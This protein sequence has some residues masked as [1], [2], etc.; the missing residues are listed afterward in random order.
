M[1]KLG[2]FF[3]GIGSP[4]LAFKKIG[5]DFELKF[6]SE[7]DPEDD[8][9]YA[10]KSYSIIHD[11]S[12]DMNLGDI[13]TI[14]ETKLPYCDIYTYGFPCQSFSMQGK[15]LGF[16]DPVKGNLFFETMRIANKNK[17]KILIAENVKGLIS[18]D[19][20]N[21]FK[22]ILETLDYIGYN[23]YYSIL[24]SC[25][26]NLPHNRERIF[27]VSIRKDVDNNLFKMPIGKLT[28]LT[29]NDILDTTENRKGVKESLLNYFNNKYFKINYESPVGIKKL[30]DGVAEGY[31]TSSFTSNR[32]FST[33]G[34]SPT[35][36]TKNDAVYYEINGH[37]TQK[38]RFRLQGIPDEY[39]YRL[40]D[41]G[42]PNGALDKISGNTLSVNVFVAIIQELKNA[43]LFENYNEINISC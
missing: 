33:N 8:K 13:N 28:K 42:I 19:N 27:I 6:Y 38:E 24:N 35:L 11:I 22:T 20:G 26:F 16:E 25:Y 30:F 39:F 41:A 17:P 34:I 7:F 15:R 43:R 31:F 37:L 12:E 29:V 2:S 3:S 36:T 10:S 9:Q 14:N 5:L 40:K 23:N 21:T 4:E 18:H 1:I 32:I